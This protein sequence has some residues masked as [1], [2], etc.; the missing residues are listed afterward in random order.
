VAGVAC[1]V[2]TVAHVVLASY[3]DHADLF[4]AMVAVPSLLGE[5]A[6]AR[7]LLVQGGKVRTT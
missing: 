2:D 3:Q 4:L 5:L 7:W 1:I 6:F